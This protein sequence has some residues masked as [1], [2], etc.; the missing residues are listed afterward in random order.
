MTYIDRSVHLDLANFNICMWLLTSKIFMT[1][2]SLKIL[3]NIYNFNRSRQG[4]M[5]HFKFV[6]EL[7]LLKYF[8]VK[9]FSNLN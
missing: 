8:P 9:N 2:L 1:S 4:E 3:L 7:T 5:F 6:V